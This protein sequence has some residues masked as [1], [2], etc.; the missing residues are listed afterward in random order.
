MMYARRVIR[1]VD[2]RTRHHAAGRRRA[3]RFVGNVD[4]HLVAVALTAWIAL[5]HDGLADRRLLSKSH[6]D[7]RQVTYGRVPADLEQI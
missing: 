7:R 6:C 5:R 2:A 4:P 3:R 1:L